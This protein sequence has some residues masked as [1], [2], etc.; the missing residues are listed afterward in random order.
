MLDIIELNPKGKVEKVVIWLHG[1]GAS[2]NDFLPIKSYFQEYDNLKFIFPNAPKRKI[3]IN[4]NMVMPGWYDIKNINLLLDIDTAGIQES[5]DEINNLIELQIQKYNISPRD[6]IL[7]GFSQG[8]AIALYNLMTSD[9]NVGTVIGLSTYIPM[10]ELKLVSKPFDTR[11]MIAHGM[12]DP[13][14]P[15]HLGVRSK[16][17]LKDMN[18]NVNWKQLPIQHTVSQEE[19]VDTVEFIKANLQGV[20]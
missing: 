19:L 11:I 2:G 8:G 18:L 17:F 5:S 9:V 16:D 12:F 3:S 14:V 15:F 10:S 1:L 13:I 7:G 4:N 6:I 20:H